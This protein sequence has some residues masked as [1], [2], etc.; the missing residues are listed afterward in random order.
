M[1]NCPQLSP[2]SPAVQ[3]LLADGMSIAWVAYSCGTSQG[4]K[5][6]HTLSVCQPGTRTLQ[7]VG[8]QRFCVCM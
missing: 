5:S 6:T 4:E 3:C 7:P 8:R 2:L 1:A